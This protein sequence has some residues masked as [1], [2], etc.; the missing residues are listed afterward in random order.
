MK[1]WII[2]PRDSLIVRDGR[3]FG[4]GSGIRATSLDFPFPSTTTGGVR[5]RAGLNDDGVFDVNSIDAVKEIGTAGPLLIELDQ[6]AVIRDWLMP[7]PS[8][9]L[10]VRDESDEAKVQIKCL[11]PINEAES[12]TN[13][14]MALLPV[15]VRTLLR[16]KPTQGP[17]F[18]HWTQ[19]K[20]WLIESKDFSTSRKALGHDG[21]DKDSRVHASLNAS[22][23]TGA[24]GDNNLFQT[25]GL[26]FRRTQ[27]GEKPQSARRLALAVFVQD[28]AQAQRIKTGLAPLGG[29]RRLV[30]WREDR[31]DKAKNILLCPDLIKSKIINSRCCRLVLL[32][33]AFF[34]QGSNPEWVLQPRKG[35]TAKLKAIAHNHYLVVSGWDFAKVQIKNDKQIVGEP[36][37]T[38]R[39]VPAG[40][41]LFLELDGNN[42]GEWIDDTWFRC[43]SD[44]D[45]TG[46][47]N[48][49][50]DG[51]GLAMLGT[52]D[53]IPLK[54]E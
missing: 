21:P 7:A 53:G 20:E 45:P 17:K 12:S 35:V 26:E 31:G 38:R 16:G 39:L 33:P 30:V 52:W 49:R 48:P 27:D 34:N 13:I 54:V 42:I 36:K 19:F 3:P 50:K 9:A 10:I 47:L 23:T 6:D 32:T 18:W 4:V 1:T 51:F 28:S 2:E 15:G 25:R 43:I 24:T 41:V 14:E 11:N 44:D 40:A 8:D 5:T 37:P 46:P 29:E 22:F